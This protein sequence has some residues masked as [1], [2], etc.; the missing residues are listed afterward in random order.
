[1]EALK[2]LEKQLK[3]LRGR[4]CKAHL[5]EYHYPTDKETAKAEYIRNNVVKPYDKFCFV[6]IIPDDLIAGIIKD[7]E[8]LKHR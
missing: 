4:I 2:Q 6:E 7:E 3:R 8:E 1:M 5:I